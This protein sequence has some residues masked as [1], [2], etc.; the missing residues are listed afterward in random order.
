MA[1]LNIDYMLKLGGIPAMQELAAK[2]SSMLYDYFDS[3][4]GYYSNGI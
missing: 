1:G 2:R 4:D 3:S